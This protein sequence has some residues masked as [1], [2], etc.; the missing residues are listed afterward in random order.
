MRSLILRAIIVAAIIGCV[1]SFWTTGSVRRENSSA[2]DSEQSL[3][4]ANKVAAQSLIL[5][6]GNIDAARGVAPSPIV[7][8]GATVGG[9]KIEQFTKLD[10]LKNWEF[11]I[12]NSSPRP[13]M[14]V[15]FRLRVRAANGKA[16]YFGVVGNYGY[17]C[18]FGNA[19]CIKKLDP[20]QKARVRLNSEAIARFA[21]AVELSSLYSIAVSGSAAAGGIEIAAAE[22]HY[23]DFGLFLNGAEM[24]PLE[25]GRYVPVSP[26]I[27]ANREALRALIDK[28]RSGQ[29]LKEMD[30]GLRKKGLTWEYLKTNVLISPTA[31]IQGTKRSSTG[32]RNNGNEFGYQKE[33]K[34]HRFGDFFA[35][36]SPSVVFAQSGPCPAPGSFLEGP[37][38][39]SVRCWW[40]DGSGL[41]AFA[42]CAAYADCLQSTSA[43]GCQSIFN[44]GGMGA[45]CGCATIGTQA[46][47][48]Y[49]PWI[50]NCPS[51]SPGCQ[52]LPYP[53]VCGTIT[54][55]CNFCMT[56]DAIGLPVNC[57]AYDPCGFP[58]SRQKLCNSLT[59]VDFGCGTP[60]LCDQ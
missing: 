3:F 2:I 28:G 5:K 51:S 42:A 40:A 52:N 29:I 11:D 4:A 60:P 36:L 30:D 55:G 57:G 8:L 24:F 38:A 34:N 49:V 50:A 13:V 12:Q 43:G 56:T 10:D 17:N 54:Y 32:G 48:C 25:P 35:L 39:Y 19:P 59:E 15:D 37:Q 26:S 46:K 23:L 22:V 21:S 14:Y 33:R 47:Y 44:Y 20:G 31:K 18:I 16:R 58:V 45:N 1:F 27:S 9:N 53:G 7:I 41:P 6:F